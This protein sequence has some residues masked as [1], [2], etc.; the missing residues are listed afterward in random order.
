MTPKTDLTLEI[1][2]LF[3]ECR[4][5]KEI[6]EKD[7]YPLLVD[8]L[9]SKF[10]DR[11]EVEQNRPLILKITAFLERGKP[12]LGYSG[13][14]ADIVLY[15]KQE[16]IGIRDDDQILRKSGQYAL[17]RPGIIYPAIIVQVITSTQTG[18]LQQEN[19]K[20]Q[21][22]RSM[23]PRALL[24]LLA[25][26]YRVKRDLRFDRDTSFFDLVLPGFEELN[27]CRLGLASLSAMI[28]AHVDAKWR[29]Y[30]KMK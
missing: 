18:K 28:E 16:A 4:K 12:Y 29:Y 6:R 14:D 26:A 15:P 10:G 23:F 17:R 2:R 11:M 9:R 20:A 1:S 19:M 27:V 30:G 5:K 7:I 25:G 3:R 22:W 8:F 13:S 24:V 21:A